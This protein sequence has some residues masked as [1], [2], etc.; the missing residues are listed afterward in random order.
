MSNW[1]SADQV[2]ERFPVLDEV[3][4]TFAVALRQLTVRSEPVY[5][6]GRC[7]DAIPYYDL[8]EVERYLVS[9]SV[10]LL[11]PQGDGPWHV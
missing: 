11:T 10:K 4:L 6:G 2:R 5:V 1:L 9:E 8:E 7:V 3:S